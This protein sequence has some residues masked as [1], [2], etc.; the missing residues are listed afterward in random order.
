M[1]LCYDS[2]IKLETV[3]CSFM[4]NTRLSIYFTIILY[5]PHWHYYILRIPEARVRIF[6]RGL[7]IFTMTVIFLNSSRQTSGIEL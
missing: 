6:A 2:C 5:I 1:P 7:A 3:H 4:I